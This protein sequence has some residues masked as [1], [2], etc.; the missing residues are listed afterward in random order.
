MTVFRHHDEAKSVTHSL[1]HVVL[2]RSNTGTSPELAAKGNW[3]VCLVWE[4]QD[5]ELNTTTRLTIIH[6]IRYSKY[7]PNSGAP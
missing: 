1:G 6:P 7:F 5:I 3:V 4:L 2:R